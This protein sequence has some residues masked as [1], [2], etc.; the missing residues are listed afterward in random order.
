MGTI[1]TAQNTLLTTTGE[2]LVEYNVYDKDGNFVDTHSENVLIEAPSLIKPINNDL[3]VEFLRPVKK[4]V[5]ETKLKKLNIVNNDPMSNYGGYRMDFTH[6]SSNPTTRAEVEVNSLSLSGDRLIKGLTKTVNT[7]DTK[8]NNHFPEIAIQ[9]NLNFTSVRVGNKYQVGFSYYIENTVSSLNDLDYY[10]L[11]H[12]SI[13]DSANNDSYYYD[14]E[15]QKFDNFNQ[16]GLTNT[17]ANQKY[18]KYIKNTNRDVWNNFKIELESVE[19]ITSETTLLS[20]NIRELTY[21]TSAANTAHTAYY[22]DNFFIDQIWDESTKF[23]AERNSSASTTL[24]G[25]HKTEDLLLSNSL[26]DSLFDGGF[27]GQFYTKKN[28]DSSYFKLD[29]LITQEILNDYREYIKR[30]EGTF[31]NAN[32]QPIPVALHNKLWLNFSAG[33]ESISGYI[34]SMRYDVKSNQYSIV[35]HLPN[36]DDDFAST[37]S[38]KYE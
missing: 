9:N 12:I 23:I 38:I 10:F 14:F 26:G 33:G 27:D 6:P 28:G 20:F 37:F 29:E 31:Y 21:T 16:T 4:V 32:P 17:A 1:A 13:Y 5:R 2:E 24:T 8:V 36:Q 7:G 11:I 35:M 19:E 3:T 25:I 22:I 15:N 30:F 18:F 34:D